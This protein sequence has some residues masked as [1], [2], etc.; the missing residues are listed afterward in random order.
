MHNHF[1]LYTIFSLKPTMRTLARAAFMD[2]IE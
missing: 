2:F 1:S